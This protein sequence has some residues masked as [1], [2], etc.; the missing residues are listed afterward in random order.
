MPT[1]SEVAQFDAITNDTNVAQMYFGN[2][3]VTHITVGAIEVTSN[4]MNPISIG[5]N[6]TGNDT[7]VFTLVGATINGVANT[8]LR[9]N[10]V[11]LL[12]IEHDFGQSNPDNFTL[13]LGNTTD[14]VIN[15]DGTGGI[16]ID[17]VIT[18]STNKHLTLGG[19]GTGT[20]TLSQNNSYSGGTTVNAATLVCPVRA[21]LDTRAASLTVNGGTLDLGGTNQTVGNFTGT[22]GTVLNNGGGSRTLTIGNGNGSG[23]NYQGV[24]AD[25]TSGAGTM[26]LT[27][28]GTGT[29]ALSGT[30]T[31]SGAVNIN[32]GALS[33]SNVGNSGSSSNLG[34]NGTINFGRQHRDFALHRQRRNHQQGHQSDWG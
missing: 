27:K 3:G 7:A 13:A 4:R 22:G 33:V 6:G 29:I 26:A 1:S 9:N 24:I 5:S 30:N 11:Y 28:T 21:L 15:I 20:L 2:I 19:I 18:G 10:S 8:I 23:G 34:T 12:S 31:F 32:A 14:N 25:H 16:T 17:A